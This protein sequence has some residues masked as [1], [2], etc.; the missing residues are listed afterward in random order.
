MRRPSRKK[1]PYTITIE[2]HLAENLRRCGHGNLSLG[3]RYAG[4]ARSLKWFNN[5]TDGLEALIEAHDSGEPLDSHIDN[6]VDLLRIKRAPSRW[7]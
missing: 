6:L 4:T 5:V 1:H 2:P 7:D 3:V